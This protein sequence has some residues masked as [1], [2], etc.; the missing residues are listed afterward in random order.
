MWKANVVSGL[1]TGTSYGVRLSVRT[2]ATAVSGRVI[3]VGFINPSFTGRNSDFNLS[4][5]D[6]N[7][8]Y[9]ESTSAHPLDRQVRRVDA[10]PHRHV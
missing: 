10:H 7:F 4:N 9:L 3:R 2:S 1:Q 6:E 5:F 8:I